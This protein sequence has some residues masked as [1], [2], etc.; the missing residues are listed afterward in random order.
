MR[1]SAAKCKS[2]NLPLN[3]RFAKASPVPFR[4]RLLVL[5]SLSVSTVGGAQ[6]SGRLY[7]NVGPEPAEERQV[8]SSS[9]LAGSGGQTTRAVSTARESTAVTPMLK[10]DI[11]LV[12]QMALAP[13]APA[14]A[15]RETAIDVVVPVAVPSKVSAQV[16]EKPIVVAQ[17]PGAGG[18]NVPAVPPTPQVP[19]SPAP[20]APAP[21]DTGGPKF[22]IRAFEVEGS[23]LI[24]KATFDRILA[25]FAGKG[26]DFSTVQL[27]LE[28]VEKQFIAEGFGSV[29]V[30]L[31]EQE[32]DQGTVKF[33]V[34]EAKIAKIVVEGNNLYSEA[35]ILAS[36]PGF[37]LGEAPN[38]NRIA[39]SLR[40]ANENPG[41]ATTVLLRAGS[42]EGE[43]DAVVK[44]TE[45]KPIKYNFSFDNTGQGGTAR[46]G[47]FR[48]GLGVTDANFLGLDHVLAA[49]VITSPEENSSL[50]FGSKNVLILGLSYR[51]PLYSLGDSLDFSVGYS[52]VNS[53]A[54]QNIF[55]VSGRGSVFGIRYTQNLPRIGDFDH[56]LIYAWDFRAY[57]N[58]VVPIGGGTGI[59]PNIT[60]KPI[61]LTYSGSYRG[62]NAETN[63]YL[64]YNQNTPGGGNG[65]SGQWN[66][67]TS[68]TGIGAREG[69]RP[70]YRIWR[71]GFTHYWAFANDW[72]VRAN[73]VGQ[74]TND[75]L[76]AAEQFGLGGSQSIRGFTERQFSNDWGMYGNF[77]A[78]TPELL[79]K[80][81]IESDVK[82]R[83][84]AFHDVGRLYRIGPLA[85]EVQ[86]S[87]ASSQGFGIR[88]TKGNN[89]SIRLDAAWTNKPTA[90]GNAQPLVTT[91]ARNF[92]MHGALVYL[93]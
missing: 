68:P 60:V 31:P 33:K 35:N 34:I 51:V 3:L 59:I 53:G 93:F 9:L 70:N 37:K 42:N 62:Q 56:R 12:L 29:Q 24:T 84:M 87:F 16:R 86:Q 54:V 14:V 58:S 26:R 61:S 21:A 50:Q 81:K 4:T 36:L 46:T 69:G 49:Q 63:F 85:T 1:R 19:V 2:G 5:A 71:Y 38:N 80:F 57:E 75:R 39:S 67:G 73:I 77:E 43:V 83:L 88:L 89:L 40:L 48:Y 41:K 79:S 27:A 78:Y 28:A 8:S 11:P 6:E 23:T 65:G 82:L 64:T 7:G 20:K 74:I 55:N 76:I 18:A 52:N 92:R 15:P 91:V 90:T 30:L 66:A 25:P 17:A 47:T 32:L 44:V 45:D 72:Q 13:S 10:A 22:E